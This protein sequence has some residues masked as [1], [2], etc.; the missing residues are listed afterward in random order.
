MVQVYNGLEVRASLPLRHQRAEC[1]PDQ[2]ETL[3]VSNM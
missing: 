3:A 2:A 1:T